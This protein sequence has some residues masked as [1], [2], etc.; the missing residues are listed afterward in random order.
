MQPQHDEVHIKNDEYEREQQRLAKQ[1]KRVVILINGHI[2]AF[3]AVQK[4]AHVLKLF[5]RNTYALPSFSNT[6]HFIAHASLVPRL[7][8]ALPTHKP[9]NEAMHMHDRKVRATPTN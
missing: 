9:R 3:C 2:L 1:I 7:V 6:L 8:R 4:C 5:Q